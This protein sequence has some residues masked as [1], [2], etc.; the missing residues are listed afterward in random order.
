MRTRRSPAPA[1]GDWGSIDITS[2]S[3][4]A[5]SEIRYAGAAAPY[6]GALTVGDGAEP[7]IRDTTFAHNGG[8]TLADNRAAALNAG[9][10]GP[11][12]S[13]TGNTFYDNDL[14]MLINGDV[15]L[16]DS[17]VFHDEAGDGN[18]LDLIAMDGT[19]HAVNGTTTWAE[20]EVPVTLYGQVLSVTEAGALSIGDDAVMKL[21]NSRIDVSGAMDLGTGVWLTSL[22]DDTLCGDSNGDGTATTP[23]H[24]DWAG[25]NLCFDGCDWATWGEI[26][27]A[28]YP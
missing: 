28:E 24:G 15:S 8:G 19:S 18:V 10:A 27:Y 12:V 1:P 14:P 17:N 21:W 22:N 13:I 6:T 23:A 4:L 5:S 25:V 7:T 2:A 9:G 11:G 16:D 26:L 20:T 3:D